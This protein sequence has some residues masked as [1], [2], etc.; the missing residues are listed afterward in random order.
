MDI[1]RG[2]M[3]R[4]TNMGQWIYYSPTGEQFPDQ[5]FTG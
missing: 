4:V 1:R 2:F 5:M 3:I